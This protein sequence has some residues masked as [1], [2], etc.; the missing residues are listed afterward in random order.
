M[1]VAN[2]PQKWYG[3]NDF[4][5]MAGMIHKVTPNNYLEFARSL[6]ASDPDVKAKSEVLIQHLETC[7]S[8]M[9]SV[10]SDI[11]DIEFLVPYNIDN[12]MNVESSLPCFKTTSGLV[13]ISQS[14]HSKYQY[15]VWSTVSI[16]PEYAANGTL[17]TQLNISGTPPEDKVL[18]HITNLCD[19]CSRAK[20]S[21][22]EE[23]MESIYEY[24][25]TQSNICDNL[26]QK[27]VLVVHIPQHR[28]FVS[29]SQVMENLEDEILPYL[30][31]A[32]TRYGKYYDVF[33]RMGMNNQANCDTYAQVLTR[34]Y[35]CNMQQELQLR[36]DASYD[37]GTE[38]NVEVSAVPS[39]TYC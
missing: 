26:K 25:K 35:E 11:E 2:L 27:D 15:V 7:Y 20:C 34:I 30:Y 32:P 24:L 17:L 31:E 14:V 5:R 36:G 9:K 29:A 19:V 28:V 18:Q 1:K 8:D 3:W 4:L 16:L 12:S 22:K 6:E 38:W 10:R 37:Y 23:V 21:V 13:S 39:E 33:K